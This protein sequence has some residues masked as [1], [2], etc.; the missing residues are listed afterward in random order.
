MDR[1]RP[2]GLIDAPA[3]LTHG[4]ARL[5]ELLRRSND[6]GREGRRRG[7]VNMGLLKA[8]RS[9][10]REKDVKAVTDQCELN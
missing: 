5:L 8:A 4:A 7:G 2:S 1:K 10:R 9:S 6:S 3:L